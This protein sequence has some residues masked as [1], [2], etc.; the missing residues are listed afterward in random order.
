VSGRLRRRARPLAVYRWDPTAA[1][2]AELRRIA[3][4]QVDRAIAELDLVDPA[5]AVH[6]IRKRSKKLRALLRLVRPVAA[7]LHRAENPRLRDLA[8]DLSGAR[9]DAASLEALGALAGA[10]DRLAATTVAT[11]RQGL[12]GAGGGE[13]DA[14][15]ALER[16]RADLLRLRRRVETDWTLPESVRGADAVVPGLRRSYAEGRDTFEEALDD[17]TTASLHEWRKRVKDHGYHCRL[18]RSAWPPVMKARASALDDLAELLGDDHDLAVLRAGLRADPDRFGGAIKA[19]ITSVRLDRRRAELQR[20]A[21][22]LGRRVYADRPKAM[23]RRIVRWWEV[24]LTDARA[25]RTDS[26]VEPGR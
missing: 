16:A 7:E 1:P 8:R 3:R 5:E 17:P 21:V 9:D 11:V 25:H 4:T 24:A 14:S 10:G 18:L 12:I 15:V 26:F 6:Q 19:G 23:E 20:D 13:A 2:A 22:R